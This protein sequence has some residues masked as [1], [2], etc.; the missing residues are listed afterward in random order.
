MLSSLRSLFRS[1]PGDALTTV[2]CPQPGGRLDAATPG[3]L[4]CLAV[5]GDGPEAVRLKRLGI[6]EGQIVEVVRAGEPMIVRTAGTRVGISRHLARQVRVE[7]LPREGTD[8]DSVA[9]EAIA[10]G[11]SAR[12]AITGDTRGV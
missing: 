11:S 8:H 3:C 12:E 6:C 1:S 10:D 2:D 9:R 7:S 5:E 4:R